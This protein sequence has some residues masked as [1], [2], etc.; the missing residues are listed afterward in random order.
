MALVKAFRAAGAERRRLSSTF[1]SEA[2]RQCESWFFL[3]KTRIFHDLVLWA[4][5]GAMLY[6]AISL[7]TAGE[8]TPGARQEID[9]ALS[10]LPSDRDEVCATPVTS[11]HAL[12]VMPRGHRLAALATVHARDLVGESFISL[13]KTDQTRL[14]IDKIFEASGVDRRLQ[15]E[16]TQSDIACGF[17]GQGCGVSIG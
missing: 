15:I 16:T 11:V 8:L 1:K 3:E 17:V 4:G 6:W 9:V 12:C 13:G 2:A 14:A 7:W 5:A 10:V